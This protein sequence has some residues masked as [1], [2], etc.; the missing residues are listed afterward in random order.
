MLKT[1]KNKV[2]VKLKNKDKTNESGLVLTADI[3]TDSYLAEV[4]SVSDENLDLIKVNSSI[5]ISK[6][7]GSKI[8]YGNIEYLVVDID[9]ILAIIEEE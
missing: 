6:F 7:A 1:L 2:I 8:K 4:I 5:I 9:D 3:E